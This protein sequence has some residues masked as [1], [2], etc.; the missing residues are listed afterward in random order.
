MDKDIA[1]KSFMNMVWNATGGASKI[2]LTTTRDFYRHRVSKPF[3]NRMD[4]VF[5][6]EP[7]RPFQK[8]RVNLSTTR[9]ND[10]MARIDRKLKSN[11]EQTR[12]AVETLKQLLRQG[13]QP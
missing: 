13:A 2:R 6:N 1:Y 3:L 8:R 12:N 7:T 9:L 4:E 5:A 10:I 11:P